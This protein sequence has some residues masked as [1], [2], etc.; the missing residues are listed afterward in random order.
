MWLMVVP[1]D[2]VCWL[3]RWLPSR[4]MG[5]SSSAQVTVGGGAPLAAHISENC[6]PGLTTFSLKDETMRGVPSAG[7]EDPPPEGHGAT[8]R[9]PARPPHPGRRGGDKADA[10]HNDHDRAPMDIDSCAIHTAL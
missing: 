3:V 8:E 7:R 2:M 10:D 6:S 9:P 5:S 1:S 4:T